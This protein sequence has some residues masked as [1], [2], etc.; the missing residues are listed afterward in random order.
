[1]PEFFGNVS[2]GYDIGKFSGRL[3][4]FHQ[5]EH[6]IS[7]SATG[8]GDQVTNAFTRMDLAL[9]QGLT[10]Y[11]SV[12][13]NLSNLTNIEDGTSMYNRVFERRLFDRSEKYGMTA[14]FGITAE[15]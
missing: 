10:S 8:L 14:D 12:F 9:K 13:L 1:M 15:F 3:S 2:L 4:V 5:G 7:Y 11:L 6:N